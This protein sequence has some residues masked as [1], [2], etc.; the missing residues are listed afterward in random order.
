MPRDDYEKP[1]R[2]RTQDFLIMF[3]LVAML[4]GII[5]FAFSLYVKGNFTDGWSS[6]VSMQAVWVGVFGGLIMCGVSCLG[7]YAAR[8]N[9]K[10]YLC[11]Y[12]LAVLILMAFQIASTV[13][14]FNYASA[15]QTLGQGFS[16]AISDP[17]AQSINNGIL[18]TFMRCC[19]GCP[20]PPACN[21]PNVN[22]FWPGIQPYCNGTTSCAVPQI[23]ASNVDDNCFVYGPGQSLIRPTHTVDIT[24]C[25][26]LSGLQAG[27]YPIV[28]YADQG[29]CARGNPQVFKQSIA[30]YVGPKLYFVGV[31]FAVITVIQST[32]L[33]VGSYVL[34]CVSRAPDVEDD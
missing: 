16:G 7:C 29:G 8:K 4:M 30:T 20:P 34:F 2:H 31:I 11:W 26:V 21:N 32:V 28:G 12:L 18:S 5:V 15:F 22:S 9:K 33:F 10:S 3:N 17:Y 6:V 13:V 14:M 25:S 24:L 27:G 19:S 1:E 23:C